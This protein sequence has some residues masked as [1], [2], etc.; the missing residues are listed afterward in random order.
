V[1]ALGLVLCG[2]G[3]G[4]AQPP[5]GRVDVALELPERLVAGDR[6]TIVAKV[7]LSP[8]DESGELPLLVTPASEG[9][10]IEVVRGRLIRPDAEDP[11]AAEL[12]FPVPIVARNPG[13]SVLRVHVLAYAC[14]GGRCRAVTGET[15]AIVRVERP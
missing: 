15:S 10:A 3:A 4:A 12:R 11:T 8:R 2:A 7:R 9:T 1:A 5:A 6:A 13:T 14:A